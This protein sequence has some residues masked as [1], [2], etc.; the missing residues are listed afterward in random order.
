MVCMIVEAVKKRSEERIKK[1]NLNQMK[2]GCA[3]LFKDYGTII[4]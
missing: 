4:I 1:S 3:Q 2:R